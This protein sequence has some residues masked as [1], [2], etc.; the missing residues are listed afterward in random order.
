MTVS[1]IPRRRSGLRNSLSRAYPKRTRSI[2]LT[3]ASDR[4]LRNASSVLAGKRA[5]VQHAIGR[6]SLF[7]DRPR[8]MTCSSR[9][10]SS[11]VN[12]A[13][14]LGTH[15]GC[16]WDGVDRRS[17]SGSPSPSVH[18][19]PVRCASTARAPD[20]SR[21]STGTG[22]LASAMRES[23]SLAGRMSTGASAGQGQACARGS[24]DGPSQ[25]PV[26]LSNAECLAHTN[27]NSFRG[28]DVR[29]PCEHY[30]QREGDFFTSRALVAF[31]LAHSL[32]AR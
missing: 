25:A 18:L 13:S 29:T 22:A 28:S 6:A 5:R 32:R 9:I 3:N 17:S 1:L 21:R 8:H 2:C 14:Y 23:S 15:N 19:L 10:T 26:I 12:C 16:R 20:D 30:S 11:P 24:L 4:S 7:F 27:S 31:P